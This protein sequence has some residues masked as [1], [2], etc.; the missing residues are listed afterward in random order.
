MESVDMWLKNTKYKKG[1]KPHFER[2]RGLGI[3][4]E[5]AKPHIENGGLEFY[6]RMQL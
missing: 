2:V 3:T 6:T 5:Q 1:I 4:Y